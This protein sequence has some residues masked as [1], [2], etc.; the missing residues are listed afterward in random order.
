MLCVCHTSS[1]S[2]SPGR[3]DRVTHAT[4]HRRALRELDQLEAG[5]LNSPAP[6]LAPPTCKRHSDID[7]VENRSVSRSHS[8]R[9]AGMIG[10]SSLVSKATSV[11]AQ[12]SPSSPAT[13]QLPATCHW[14]NTSRVRPTRFLSFPNPSVV[15]CDTHHV[16]PTWTR[17]YRVR[18]PARPPAAAS[19]PPPPTSHRRPVA[20]TA[21]TPATVAIDVVQHH[22]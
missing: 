18:Q 2:R 22:R 1:T 8:P 15:S 4:R 11:C 17:T 6:T 12:P 9:R 20:P 16:P 14:I 19:S 21:I 13:F 10:A 3:C 5:D 7:R